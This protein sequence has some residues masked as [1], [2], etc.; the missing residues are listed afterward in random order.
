MPTRH[1]IIML[2]PSVDVTVHNNVLNCT[3][4]QCVSL[5]ISPTTALATVT[6]LPNSN[7]NYCVSQVVC[8]LC[9]SVRLGPILQYTRRTHHVNVNVGGFSLEIMIKV[10][11]YMHALANTGKLL[12]VLIVNCTHIMYLLNMQARHH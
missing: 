12:S 2:T 9:L 8:T 6:M 7:R 3:Q 4:S 1:Y 11:S 10:S 5:T